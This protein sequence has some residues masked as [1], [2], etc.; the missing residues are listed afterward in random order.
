MKEFKLTEKEKEDILKW[1]KEDLIQNRTKYTA[2][3]W[4]GSPLSD[5]IDDADEIIKKHP[6]LTYEDIELN[7][8]EQPVQWEDYDD[9][10]MELSCPS[11][12]PEAL[13][14][15]VKQLEAR[16]LDSKKQRYEIFLKGKEE[17][18]GEKI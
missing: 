9:I 2:G 1:A 13:D 3:V 7:A 11:K 10:V 12:T 8:W 18:E 4:N 17:F 16:A 5:I 14:D 15:R 6:E